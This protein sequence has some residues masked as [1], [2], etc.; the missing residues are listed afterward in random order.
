MRIDKNNDLTP[1]P[2]PTRHRNNAHF[3]VRSL[4]DWYLQ[5][6]LPKVISHLRPRFPEVSKINHGAGSPLDNVNA[7]LQIPGVAETAAV[8]GDDDDD[9]TGIVRLLGLA[10]LAKAIRKQE[11][12]ERS[13]GD[14]VAE[15]DGDDGGAASDSD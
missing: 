2:T 15:D 7:L 4:V 8:A 6:S 3:T 13:M 14:V 9:D 10:D 11:F 1:S 12:L 5:L